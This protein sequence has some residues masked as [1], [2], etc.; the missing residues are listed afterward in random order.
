MKKDY[1]IPKL[2]NV[3]AQQ[4]MA[5]RFFLQAILFCEPPAQF[6]LIGKGL[7]MNM[8]RFIAFSTITILDRCAA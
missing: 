1:R 4:E 2:L 7:K 8:L 3:S 6:A 5:Y